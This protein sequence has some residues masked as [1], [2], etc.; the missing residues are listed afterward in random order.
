MS[1]TRQTVSRDEALTIVDRAVSEMSI[2]HEKLP[3]RDAVGRILAEDQLSRLQLPPFNKSAMDGYAILEGDKRDKYEAHPQT[4]LAGDSRQPELRPG[5]AV[6]VMTG[7]PVPDGAGRVIPV[8]HVTA[9]D[10]TIEVMRTSKTTHIC[11]QGEDIQVGDVVVRAG[12]RLGAVEIANLIGC[13]ITEVDVYRPIRLAVLSTGNEIVDDP[14]KLV[15]GKIMNTNGPMLAMLAR[16]YSMDVV[17]EE[18]IPD[19]LDY[20]VATIRKAVECADIVALSGGVSVGDYDFVGTALN[21][22]GLEV[23]F[24]K[25]SIKPGRPLT[26]ATKPGVA[27]F[28]L[29]GNPVSVHIMFHVFVLRAVAGM[30]GG[31]SCLREIELPLGDD[32]RRRKTERMEYVPARLNDDGTVSAVDYHGSAHLT[33]LTESDGFFVVPIGTSELAAGERVTFL[34]LLKGRR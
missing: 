22:A 18:S 27:V 20:T 24:N 1:D 17:L 9:A 14:G 11:R 28:G 30:C 6:K 10:D 32:F 8:E 4:I 31:E 15:H 16:R 2:A 19:N 7:A 3:V 12:T 33:A 34:S 25:V 29:P 21:D 26:F 13:G 23:H 5:L